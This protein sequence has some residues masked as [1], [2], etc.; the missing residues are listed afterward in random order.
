MLL[1]ARWN[2]LIPDDLLNVYNSR[3][4]F[5]F[6][7]HDSSLNRGGKKGMSILFH[8]FS[9]VWIPAY[10]HWNLNVKSLFKE[11]ICSS[12]KIPDLSINLEHFSIF[13]VA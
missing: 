7:L 4:I 3:L 1:A 12:G 8:D 9:V 13:S 11:A 5:S 2:S 6:L 10:P